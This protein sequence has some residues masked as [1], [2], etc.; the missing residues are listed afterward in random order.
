MNSGYD[1]AVSSQKPPVREQIKRGFLYAGEIVGGMLL[2]ALAMQG[3]IGLFSEAPSR[4][5]RGPLTAWVELGVATIII[6][7][8]AERW[9]GYVPGFLFLYNVLKGFS[10]ALIPPGNSHAFHSWGRLEWLG[11]G[12]YFTLAIVL[13][14]RFVPPRKVRATLLDRMA[15]TIFALS[16]LIVGTLPISVAFRF[17]LIGLTA[18]LIAWMAYRFE[19]R[20]HRRLATHAS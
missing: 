15:L 8:T 10:Y 4:H 14:W 17:P 2:C 11:F 12:A 9:A 13:L 6:F 3:F 1:A 18:L 19:L 16:F 7:A 5:F 20:K